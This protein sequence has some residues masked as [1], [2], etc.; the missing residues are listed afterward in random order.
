MWPC[1][2][3]TVRPVYCKCP[4]FICLQGLTTGSNMRSSVFPRGHMNRT[5]WGSTAESLYFRSASTGCWAHTFR[6][7]PVVMYS[8]LAFMSKRMTG[9]R[10]LVSGVSHYDFFLP[11]TD[12][13]YCRF[14]ADLGGL[15]FIFVCWWLD[16][17]SR[18]S[19]EAIHLVTVVENLTLVQSDWQV[20]ER[21]KMSLE[22]VHHCG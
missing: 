16:E 13:F 7:H 21:H 20:I 4:A 22:A 8:T 5:S 6:F 17:M 9:I 2:C 1:C 14:P 11:F 19:S 15:F 3:Q 10:C 12:W 18:G